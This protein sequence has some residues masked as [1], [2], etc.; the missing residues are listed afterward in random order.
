[1]LQNMIIVRNI[2]LCSIEIPFTQAIEHHI[3]FDSFGVIAIFLN[4][5]YFFGHFELWRPYCYKI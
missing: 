3:M 2:T 1:M 4:I 5:L